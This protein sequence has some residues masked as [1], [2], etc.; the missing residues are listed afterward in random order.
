[1]SSPLPS[2]K[3]NI[4]NQLANIKVDTTLLDMVVVL[5]QHRH[6]KDFVEGKISTI[7]NLFEESKE[8]DSIVNKI[9]VNNF[10]NPLKKKPF[11][12]FSKNHG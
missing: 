1:V 5:E 3:Y 12:Y 11:L 4:L 2:S 8:E 9:G 7:A 10:R 6:L